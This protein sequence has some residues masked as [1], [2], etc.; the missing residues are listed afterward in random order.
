MPKVLKVGL[1]LLFL[2]A[3]ATF[4]GDLPGPMLGLSVSPDGK[5]IATTYV[6]GAL[7]HI[8]QIDMSAAPGLL[9]QLPVGSLAPPSHQMASSLHTLTYPT[10]TTSG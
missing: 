4:G 5:F 7:W 9:T 6:K 1:F 8:Y 10:R 2:V 3:P